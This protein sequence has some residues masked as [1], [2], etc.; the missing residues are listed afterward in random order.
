MTIKSR[1]VIKRQDGNICLWNAMNGGFDG[2]GREVCY[3]LEDLLR[4]HT[5]DE[6][7]EMVNRVEIVDANELSDNELVMGFDVCELTRFIKGDYA[8]IN[9]KF[10]DYHYEYIIDV[11]NQVLLGRGGEKQV[12]LS[13][14]DIKKGVRIHKVK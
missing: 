13:F 1:V 10:K 11:Y 2:V 9:D 6:L 7:M 8:W 3:E 4:T 14:E 5:I 12:K